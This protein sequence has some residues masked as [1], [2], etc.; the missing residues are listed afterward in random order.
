MVR[1]PVLATAALALLLG[2]CGPSAAG[3]DGEGELVVF[4]AASLTDVLVELG[5][6]FEQVT[7]VAVRRNLAGTQTLVTQLLE[8]APADV[9]LAADLER[10]QVVVDAGL[11]ADEP[12]PFA[13]NRLAIAVELGNPRGVE[14]VADL[15]RA[16]LVVVLAAPEV[17][18]GR[19]AQQLLDRAGVTVRPASL[20]RDVRAALAKVRLGEADAALVYTSD[21]VAAGGAVEGV[22]IAPEQDVVATYPAV[23]LAG[24]AAP[25]AAAAFVALLHSEEGRAVLRDHGFIAP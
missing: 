23:V 22:A 18:A 8:G 12:R 3:P 21:V 24:A 20:E 11:H 16:D 14:R 13:T 5:D 1:R 17:P 10:M 6:R 7:G 2:A 9:L 19:Y 25:E 15:A 4:A